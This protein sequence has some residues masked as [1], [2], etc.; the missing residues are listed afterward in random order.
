MKTSKLAVLLA[1]FGLVQVSLAQTSNTE[2]TANAQFPDVV[3]GN[4]G[5]L[6]HTGASQYLVAVHN[7]PLD[8]TGNVCRGINVIASRSVHL[9]RTIHSNGRAYEILLTAKTITPR[10]W[11]HGCESSAESCTVR[12]KI[13]GGR[14]T[15]SVIKCLNPPS[16]VNNQS[17][18][19]AQRVVISES[20]AQSLLLEKISPNYPPLAKQA[21]ISGTVVLRAEISKEGKIQDL[22]FISGHPMLA[23]A[24]IDAV[25]QWRYKPYLVNGEPVEAGTTVGVMFN[26]ND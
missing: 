10:G 13:S 12:G 23:Q 11:G 2:A 16:A 25:R 22:R 18:Q 21:K 1:V 26:P 15:A 7:E 8:P 9:E 6:I 14:I 17:P 19:S 4:I 3:K 5:L 20:E 24:A